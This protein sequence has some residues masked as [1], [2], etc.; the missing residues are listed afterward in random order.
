MVT[1]STGEQLSFFGDTT[2]CVNDG[3][4]TLVNTKDT[5]NFMKSNHPVVADNSYNVIQIPRGGEYIVRLEDG[6]TVYL[7]SESELRIPVHFGKGERLVWLTGEA[8]FSVKHEKDRKFVVRTN[9]ADIAVLGTEFGVR[10]YLE[11]DELLTTL[12]KGSVEVKSDH[13]I[14]RIVPGEQATVDNMGKIEVREVNVD[15]FVAWKSGRV[16]FVNARLEDIMD[17]LQRWYDFNV[18]YSSP[19]LKELRFTM[20]I[21][22]YKEVSEIFE[23]MEKIKKVSFSVNGNNVILK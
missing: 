11:E 10:V 12:V 16:V 9:K 18:F 19:E 23:L 6:T 17:E 3:L 14:H 22:K 21:M 2:V 7:N 4:A 15:E 8:Y 13:D 1:L 5:L 20:D